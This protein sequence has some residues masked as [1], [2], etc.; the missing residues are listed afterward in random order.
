MS[1]PL[2]VRMHACL[3]PRLYA[4]QALRMFPRGARRLVY[5][6]EEV[7]RVRHAHALFQKARAC[8]PSHP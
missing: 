5:V 4:L 2:G 1:Q 8:A 7:F 3:W 6:L